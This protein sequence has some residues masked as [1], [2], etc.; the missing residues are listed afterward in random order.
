M[1]VRKSTFFGVISAD[2]AKTLYCHGVG[3]DPATSVGRASEE[4][5]RAH[6]VQD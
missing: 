2:V 3:F 4:E 5:S 6:G 1:M